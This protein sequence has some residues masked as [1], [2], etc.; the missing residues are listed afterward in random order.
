[1]VAKTVGE[2][3]LRQMETM[4]KNN[5]SLFLNFMNLS[6]LT[7]I[8]EILC[9]DYQHVVDLSYLEEPKL[10]FLTLT[11]QYSKD[12]SL[13]AIPPDVCIEFAR[14]FGLDTANYEII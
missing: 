5:L 7:A 3:W 13:C 6:K 11:A 10:K 1:M 2:A 14:T 4:D 8:F 9:P 12:D